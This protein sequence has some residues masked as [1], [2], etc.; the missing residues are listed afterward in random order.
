MD[1]LEK[2]IEYFE[3]SNRGDLPP[4]FEMLSPKIHYFSDQVGTFEGLDSVRAM[5]TEF[6][7]KFTVI[8]WDIISSE[9]LKNGRAS[10]V[11][12]M[13]ATE[14]SSQKRILRSGREEV[15]I[16]ENGM[17]CGIYVWIDK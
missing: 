6:F 13:R 16:D 8:K 9:I 5:M 3:K 12:Q 4:I 1:V 11:F 7:K 10:I 15:E 14:Q 17:I 2:A